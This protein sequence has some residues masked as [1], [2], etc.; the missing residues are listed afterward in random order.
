ME[1]K[2]NKATAEQ[3]TSRE[4]RYYRTPLWKTRSDGDFINSSKGSK[5]MLFAGQGLYARDPS[6]F[7]GESDHM[8]IKI[9]QAQN[10]STASIQDVPWEYVE[11]RRTTREFPKI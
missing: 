2:N 9:I 6:S 11:I 3:T 7:H 1:V 8:V 5:D 10:A 4:H